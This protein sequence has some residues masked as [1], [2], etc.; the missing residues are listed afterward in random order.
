MEEH[1][2][3]NLIKKHEL[4]PY[5]ERIISESR[6]CVSLV[7]KKINEKEIPIGCSKLG[8]K[9]DLPPGFKY[10]HQSGVTLSFIAQIN[11]EIASKFDT[12]NL[13][14]KKGFLYFFYECDKQFSGIQL[15]EKPFWRVLYYDGI[16]KD[17]YRTE[18]PDDL[19]KEFQ[20]S[21]AILN[22]ERAIS[23][24]DI[25]SDELSNVNWSD[26][27]KDGYL[28]FIEDYWDCFNLKHQLLGYPKTIQ[29]EVLTE[30]LPFIQED[31]EDF[32]LSLEDLTLLLQI[33]TDEENTDM[34]WGDEGII[35]FVMTKE[36]LR[37][38]NFNH[39]WLSL[40]SK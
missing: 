39:V 17:L 9:A 1:L 18:F 38:K 14:P 20:F 11:C 31:K 30:V 23:F 24:A 26:D 4:T 25:D 22:E 3:N 19:L 21:P 13:L 34:L 35:Y 7:A 15:K 32:N 16:D 27:I 33:E 8:G 37:N 36:D 10:P 5:Q 12:S 6:P 40:Q 29:L 2:I 28:D